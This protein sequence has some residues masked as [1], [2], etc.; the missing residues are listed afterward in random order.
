M[1]IDI[2]FEIGDEIT[3]DGEK[4]EIKGLHCFVDQEGEVSNVR[5]YIGTGGA[6]P[7]VMLMRKTSKKV[8]GKNG[9]QLKT[10]RRK[11]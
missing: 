4:V 1:I 2:P 6:Q 3:V 8:S 5:A 10:K 9:G 7:Y 11:V